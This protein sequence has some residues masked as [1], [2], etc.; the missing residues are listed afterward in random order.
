MEKLGRI[1]IFTP[2][3]VGLKNSIL[4]PAL[5]LFYKKKWGGDCKEPVG[6]RQTL[7]H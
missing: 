2:S 6:L 4:W 7:D 3:M 5:A 1:L